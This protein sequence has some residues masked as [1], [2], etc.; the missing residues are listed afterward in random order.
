MPV[1]V[2]ARFKPVTE[3]APHWNVICVAAGVAACDMPNTDTRLILT[4][5]VVAP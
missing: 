2:I 1:A 3:V 5:S 4:D